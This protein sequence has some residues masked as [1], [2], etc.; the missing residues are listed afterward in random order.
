MPTVEFSSD[1]PGSENPLKDVVVPLDGVE[2][3]CEGQLSILDL[4]E[5]AAKAIDD[6]T[7][8]A[9]EAAS[10][11]QTLLQSFGPAEYARFKR[12][13]HDHKTPDE[14]VV[15]IIQYL[16]EQVQAN[17]E[18]MTAR[19]TEPSSSS[20]GGREGP[21][22]QPVRS[23]SADRR[24]V[25]VV[26]EGGDVAAARAARQPKTRARGTGRRTG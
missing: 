12:H 5:L 16:N 1:V 6:A 15:K 8:D 26:E 10:Y 19:P 2:F 11:Y 4:S 7:A 24:S 25:K 18:R 14:V 13:V 17:I 20:S 22:E 9:A 3:R 21:A 23:I